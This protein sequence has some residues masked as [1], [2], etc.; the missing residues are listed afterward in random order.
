MKKELKWT[1]EIMD[2][3]KTEIPVFAPCSS[4]M[5]NCYF[6]RPLYDKAADD[7]QEDDKDG[8]EGKN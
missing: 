3:P 6:T 2:I 5:A 8:N 1:F 7:T 4:M